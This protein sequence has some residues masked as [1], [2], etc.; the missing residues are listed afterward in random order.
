LN[1][2]KSRHVFVLLGFA[3]SAAA[4]LWL[5]QTYD[6][7][8][9]LAAIAGADRTWLTLCAALVFANFVLSTL[10]WAAIFP[11]EMRPRFR[12]AFR[13]MMAGYLFN[14]V[15][16]AHAGDLVRVHLLGRGDKLPR[17]AALG[18]VLLERSLDL[19]VLLTLFAGVLLVKPLPSWATYAGGVVA[20]L[21]AIT[22]MIIVLLGAFGEHLIA[23]GLRWFRF[24]P[25][26]LLRRASVSGG[27]F[28]RSLSM[29]LR[30]A[31]MLRFVGF[32]I[33]I[34]TVALGIVYA[35]GRA[36]G[37]GL[38]P[39]SALFVMLAIMLGT[40]VPASPGYIGTFEFFGLSALALIGISGSE[41]LA[42]VITLHT[43]LFVGSTLVGIVCV[44]GGGW[45][46]I[47][48]ILK[49]HSPYASQESKK[50]I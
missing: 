42:F 7:S 25:E 39:T 36:F 50:V 5:A 1:E 44:A 11:E 10:R 6:W 9:A 4:V 21:A 38:S 13:A 31:Y 27:N 49:S 41:A 8:R 23:T 2:V 48:P 26:P 12:T 22:L 45:M 33:I 24:L 19:L 14:N 20:A 34:W 29:V 17:S 35:I 18:T 15:L 30:L 3:I 28:V 32:S 47:G 16:P 37:F 40:L 46:A 43:L